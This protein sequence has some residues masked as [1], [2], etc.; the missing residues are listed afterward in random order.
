MQQRG[1]RDQ[2]RNAKRKT[3]K[4]KTLARI[5]HVNEEYE[6]RDTDR[7]IE[8]PSWSRASMEFEQRA[9]LQRPAKR[10]KC[11]GGSNRRELRKRSVRHDEQPGTTLHDERHRPL[12]EA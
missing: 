9:Q 3:A 1:A 6:E 4:G 8:Q 7:S 11:R 12:P 10:E 5:G 2:L